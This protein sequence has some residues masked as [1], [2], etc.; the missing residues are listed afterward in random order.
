MRNRGKRK[1]SK[2]KQV[3]V[4]HIKN[5]LR[6][7]VIVLILFLIGLIFGIIFI[8]NAGETQVNDITSYLGG[9]IDNI[10]NKI[11]INQF[12]VLKDALVSNFL[13]ALIL[14]FVGSTVIGIP[15]VYGI[16]AYRGFCLGYTIS[17]VVATIGIGKGILFSFTSLLVQNILFIPCLLALAVSGMKLYQSIVKDKRRENIKTEITRHTIFCFILLIGLGLAAFA[18]V[19]ISTNLLQICARFL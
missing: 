10:K 6:E 9:F 2:L 8:N 17:S 4:Q 13:L 5:N 15:I 18:E 16:V 14:W 19:Y 3:I 11:E 1:E 7:Y 12:E